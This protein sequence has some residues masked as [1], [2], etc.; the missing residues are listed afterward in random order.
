MPAVVSDSSPFVYLTRLG[1]FDL[2]RGLYSQVWVPSAV[3]KE[4]AVEGV[5]RPEGANVKQAAADGWLI[6]ESVLPSSA[7][8]DAALLALDDGEREAIILARKLCAMLIIDE[9]EGRNVAARL[10][11]RCT[12]TIG[13]LIEA[14]LRGLIPRL[15][16]ELQR[17]KTE[18]NFRFAEEL[19]NG[20]LKKAGEAPP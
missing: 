6:V 15:Q 13:I 2:L 10:G 20:A 16:P 7:P 4:V 1:R 14:K 5:S 12:G 19:F 11:V 17:L 3:W 18:S 9:A 8:Q